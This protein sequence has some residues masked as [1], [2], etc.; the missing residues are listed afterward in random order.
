MPGDLLALA[1]K[2]VERERDAQ[3][4][5][6]EYKHLFKP[7]CLFKAACFHYGECKLFIIIMFHLVSMLIIWSHFFLV[8]FQELEN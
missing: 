7:G 5:F 8:K 2:R 1:A 6:T 4:L 3:T